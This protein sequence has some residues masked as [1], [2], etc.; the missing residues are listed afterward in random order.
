MCQDIERKESP[1]GNINTPARNRVPPQES[2]EGSPFI[3][4]CA[5]LGKDI[6]ITLFQDVIDGIQ[7]HLMIVDVRSVGSDASR[8]VILKRRDIYIGTVA[9]EQVIAMECLFERIQPVELSEQER[10]GIII[11]F[12]ALLDKS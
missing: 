2:N 4:L 9:G 3:D 12:D 10:E 5:R 1:V 7:V 11:Q 8:P 6:R